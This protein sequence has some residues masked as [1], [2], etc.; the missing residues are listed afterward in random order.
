MTE[1]GKQSQVD[2]IESANLLAFPTAL[3]GKITRYK[4]QVVQIVL[5]KGEVKKVSLQELFGWATDQMSSME[6]CLLISPSRSDAKA[7]TI[8]SSG[9]FPTHLVNH[10]TSSFRDAGGGN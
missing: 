6:G 10:C 4:E 2:K 7:G 3:D 1:I 5:Q 9:S 8:S